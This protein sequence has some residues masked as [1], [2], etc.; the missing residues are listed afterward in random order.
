MVTKIRAAGL[1]SRSGA[2]TVICNGRQETVLQQISAG[3]EIG[4]LLYARQER[5]AAR[6][7]WLAGRLQVSGR[8]LVDEGAAR[9]L[10]RGGKSLLPVGVTAVEGEFA[11]GD[12][13]SCRNS[14]GIELAR[15]L[16][17]YN[18]DEA[19][20][21][22]GCHSH[23]ISERLGYCDDEELIHRNNLVLV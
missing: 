18:S 7:Q 22:I 11:R 8:L 17:N 5:L 4:S 2:N 10:Q 13:V 9:V 6:K 16:V 14:I 19:R 15:G 21:I 12:L 3:Q 1:A 20:Q 23:Q